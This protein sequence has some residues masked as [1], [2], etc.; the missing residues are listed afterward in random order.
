MFN[1]HGQPLD[2]VGSASCWIFAYQQND[3]VRPEFLRYKQKPLPLCT[4][5]DLALSLPLTM[6]IVWNLT[7]E[8]STSS[9]N[10]RSPMRT[11][12]VSASLNCLREKGTHDI[13]IPARKKLSML[14]PGRANKW[15]TIIRP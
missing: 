2:E 6:S 4:N 3:L 15:S 5:L 14:Y 1:A 10:R 12:S 9:A 7:G 13:I 8:K 11:A